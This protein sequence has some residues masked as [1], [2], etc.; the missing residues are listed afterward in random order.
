[1]WPTEIMN[2]FGELARLNHAKYSK[3]SFLGY[4]KNLAQV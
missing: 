1:M 4:G 2:F 3:S